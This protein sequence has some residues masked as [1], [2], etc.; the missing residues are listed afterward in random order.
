MLAGTA[1]F[2]TVAVTST[3]PETTPGAK[4]TLAAPSAL[5]A[6]PPCVGS[7]NVPA[8]GARAPP[9]PPAGSV[10]LVV[11]PAAGGSPIDVGVA[12]CVCDAAGVV[13][14]LA[15]AP[16]D[17][18]SACGSLL[19]PPVVVLVEAVPLDVTVP[20]AAIALEGVAPERAVSVVLATVVWPAVGALVVA[21]GAGT[22]SWTGGL[23]GA[24][25][26]GAGAAVELAPAASDDETVSVLVEPALEIVAAG[27]D[28]IV[29]ESDVVAAGADVVAAGVVLV[30]AGADVVVAAVVLVAALAVVSVGVVAAALVGSVVV[31]PLPSP[32]EIDCS[33]RTTS[34]CAVCAIG[35]DG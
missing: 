6:V 22:W 3:A 24:A 33:A 17:E 21:G 16:D 15:G 10:A 28:V 5:A 31:V 13:V 9:D 32:P 25:V 26:G 35:V 30:V 18:G 23:G 19:V 2:D 20:F 34:G 7:T 27:V 8:G 4:T 14:P 11:A 1:V 29:G 12:G